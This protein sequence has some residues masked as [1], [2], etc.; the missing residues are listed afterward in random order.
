MWLKVRRLKCAASYTQL[1]VFLAESPLRIC[2]KALYI[3]RKSPV[4]LQKGYFK[5][6]TPMPWTTQFD[7][8]ICGIE[9]PRTGTFQ[10]ITWCCCVFRVHVFF[11]HVFY[12]GVFVCARVLCV[13]VFYVCVFA[14][15]LVFVCACVCAGVRLCVCACV[16][17]CVSC[18]RV[19]CMCVFVCVRVL[20]VH[21]QSTLV[22]H[23]NAMESSPTRTGC[24]SSRVQTLH[25]PQAMCATSA[26]ATPRPMYFPHI[27]QGP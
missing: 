10:E 11:V 24:S 8:D 5:S 22:L 18:A 16:R 26:I 27:A 17:V 14:C 25:G 9:S 3:P 4:R 2:T 23:Q 6:P 15:V 21:V 13:R 7:R 20:C 1:K 19:F 12:V